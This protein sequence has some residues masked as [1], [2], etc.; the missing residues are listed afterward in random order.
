MGGGNE[1]GGTDAVEVCEMARRCV[2]APLS[3]WC[4]RQRQDLQRATLW[5]GI[6]LEEL[7]LIMVYA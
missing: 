6:S 3:R 1:E 5:M 2:R 4:Q 7:H